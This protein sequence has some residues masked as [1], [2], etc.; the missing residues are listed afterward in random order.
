MANRIIQLQDETKTDNLYPLAGGMASDSI[1]TAM[2]Q[3]GAV[4]SQKIASATD[5]NGFTFQ[6]GVGTISLQRLATKGG[7]FSG[8]ATFQVTTAFAENEHFAVCSVKP[9][10]RTYFPMQSG[11]GFMEPNGKMYKLGGLSVGWTSFGV[12]GVIDD[13]TE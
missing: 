13:T 11:M 9:P 6:T 5:N 1:T 10:V 3:D 8:G 12:T 7:V 4:T 2:I